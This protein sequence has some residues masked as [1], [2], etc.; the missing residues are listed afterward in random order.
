[1]HVHA[2]ARR[3]GPDGVDLAQELVEA[4]VGPARLDPLAPARRR[5]EVPRSV[6]PRNA[7]RS[8]SDSSWKAS[9]PCD[10]NRQRGTLR[11][12]SSG[13]GLRRR[14]M[15]LAPASSALAHSL[16]DAMPVPMI[17]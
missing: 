8:S 6:R 12:C 7:I 14:A 11:S 5:G 3:P 4:A 9:M 17:R 15:T 13:W 2:Q 16:T 10:S 1:L